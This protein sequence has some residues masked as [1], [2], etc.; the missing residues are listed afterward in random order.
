MVKVSVMIPTYNNA[1]FVGEAIQSVLD[2]TFNDF[3][4]IVVDDGSTDNTDKV[5]SNFQD[6]RI[7]YIRQ[8]HGGAS[9]AQNTAIKVARGEY[10]SGLGSDDIWLPEKL[11]LEV[12]VLDTN[13]DIGLVCSD[14]YIMDN[15]TGNILGRRWHDKSFHNC[16][17]PE[18]AAKQPLKELL[19]RGCF[20]TPQAILV[21]HKIFEQVG[22]FDESLITH[23]DWDLF[24]RIV[25]RYSIKTID[26]PLVKIRAHDA[27]LSANWDRMYLGA[28]KVLN[29]A[30]INQLLSTK[31]RKI[32]RNRL[33]RTHYSYGKSQVLNGAT[34]SGRRILL[35]AI[36]VNPWYVQPYK[37]LVSSLFGDKII[38]NLKSLKK[39]TLGR[40]PAS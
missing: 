22:L 30:L 9:A 1:H 10:F 12:R 31:D 2:Q 33:A 40:N 18:K 29:K 21:R 28:V 17:N 26:I 39:N 32:V 35:D 36:K 37:Y 23:E 14:A 15:R 3:E 8:E 25:N 34:K 13:P 24:V 6:H 5:V 20:I 7:R 38:M 19:T 16:I 27:S 4:I 11:A